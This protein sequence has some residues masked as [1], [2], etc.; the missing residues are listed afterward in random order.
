MNL[1]LADDQKLLEETFERFFQAESSIA[2]VRA[3][4]PLGFDRALWDGLLEMGALSAS[5]QSIRPCFRS[6]SV[7]TAVAC[8]A[9]G[10]PA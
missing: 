7:A 8:T 3:A 5:A 1:H 4:E 9:A 2:R 6:T 10:K